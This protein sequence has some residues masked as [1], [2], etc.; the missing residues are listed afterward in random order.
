[1]RKRLPRS[2]LGRNPLLA[3]EQSPKYLWCRTSLEALMPDYEYHCREC[4]EVF[5]TSQTIAEH[6]KASQPA[7]PKCGSRNVE[8][9]LS[10]ATIITSKKS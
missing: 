9:L 8:Q 2:P 3:F 5:T 7:C 4:M 10:S 6:D 1:M